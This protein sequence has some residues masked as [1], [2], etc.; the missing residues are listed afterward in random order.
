MKDLSGKIAVVTGAARGIGAAITKRMLE[1]NVKGLALVGAHIDTLEAT[2]RK[3][4]PELKK[5]AVFQCDISKRDQVHGTAAKI[6]ERFG[7]VDILV[8][9]AGITRDK[10]FH[11]MDP[12]M[13]DEV[14]ATNLSSQAYFC[15]E[16]YPIMREKSYGRIVNISSTSAFGNVGQANYAASKAGIIGFT[17]TLAREGASKNIC[18]N[19]IAPGYIET[20]MFMA[21]PKEVLQQYLGSI[22]MGRMGKPEEIASVVSF[23]SGDDTSFMSGQVLI[24]SGAAQT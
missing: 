16:F 4:D 7:T 1:D 22:P 6:L 21:V 14:I 5:T 17:K 19:C 10:M 2:A 12:A 23:L 15:W 8:N 20:D 18:A 24:V 13:W 11:K 3:F 9:N